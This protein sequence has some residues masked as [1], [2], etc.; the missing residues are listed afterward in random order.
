MGQTITLLRMITATAL[1]ATAS[2]AKAQVWPPEII[3][4]YKA[5]KT[6]SDLLVCD[7]GDQADCEFY[8]T[9]PADTRAAALPI[10]EV[11]N[12]A[13]LVLKDGSAL[14]R[15]EARPE[16]GIFVVNGTELQFS[17][18]PQAAA[19]YKLVRDSLP[20]AGQKSPVHER[21]ALAIHNLVRGTPRIVIC[22]D[23]LFFAQQCARAYEIYGEIKKQGHD[24]KPNCEGMKSVMA[25]L[26]TDAKRLTDTWA[27]YFGEASTIPLKA[28]AEAKTCSYGTW[29]IDGSM[30]ACM[31]VAVT[32]WQEADGQACG[33]SSAGETIRK[34]VG[35]VK[36]RR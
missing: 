34:A 2:V 24:K 5:S 11:R 17:K 6:L 33:A 3:T 1:L 26:A 18:T 10:L 23:A 8:K 25:E 4:K 27:K 12:A 32:L 15:V 7:R 31:A 20:N 35:S 22:K 19:S 30:Q 29:D 13:T 9:L 16:A 14:V 21:L 28:D 36:P